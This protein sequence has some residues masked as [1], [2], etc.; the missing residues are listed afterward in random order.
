[1]IESMISV[2]ESTVDYFLSN[3]GQLTFLIP[4]SIAIAIARIRS[5]PDE[6]EREQFLNDRFTSR[7][8]TEQNLQAEFDALRV[9]EESGLLYRLK[10]FITKH[11]EGFTVVSL[12]AN[13]DV[14]QGLWEAGA[15]EPFQDNLGIE[16]EYV[17]S[18]VLNPE[19]T[20]IVLKVH[21]TNAD[22]IS[23][24]VSSLQ[25]YFILLDEQVDGIYLGISP[26]SPLHDM[27][28]DT[29]PDDFTLGKAFD[30][31]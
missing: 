31:R 7:V 16:V 19:T 30:G 27:Q 6:R 22:D 28:K 12:N 11:L 2:F 10:K 14:D 26:E 3:P 21:S 24:V 18:E 5:L 17:R 8:V 20:Q 13:Y 4:V 1:M 15:M 29:I 23:A 25:H 9:E